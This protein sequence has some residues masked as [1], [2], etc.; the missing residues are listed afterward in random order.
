MYVDEIEKCMMELAV[1][2]ESVN[3]MQDAIA[4]VNDA[5]NG[6]ARDEVQLY[7]KRSAHNIIIVLYKN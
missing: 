7:I 6:A 4:E 5:V 3:V 2:A 1:M